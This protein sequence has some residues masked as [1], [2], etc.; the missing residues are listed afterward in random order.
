MK[1][2]QARFRRVCGWAG[3]VLALLPLVRSGAESESGG[4]PPLTAGA[5]IDY[6]PFCLVDAAGRPDGFSVELLRAAAGAMGRAV[7]FETGYWADV[8]DWLAEGRVAV[9]P[10]VGRTPEREAL[11]D[12]T[13]P[14]LTMHG[15][16]V[17]RDDRQDV[18]TL[19]DL[20]GLRVAV[21][22]GDNAEEYLRREAR[23]FDIQATP[24]FD[25]ALRGV[26]AGDYDAVVIQQLVALR[27]IDHLGLANLR[28]A[29][30]PLADFRQAFCFAV[31]KG[32]A[33]TLALLNEGLA[34]VIADGTFRRLHAK[35]F[36][37][38]ELPV[39]RPLVIGGDHAYPPFEFL[40]D[41]GRPAGLNSDLTRAIARERG[42]DV[43]IRLGPWSE[44]VHALAAGEI[45]ALQG[46]LYTPERDRRFDFAPAHVAVEYVLAAPGGTGGAPESLAQL[47]GRRVA[48]QR[49]DVAQDFL[50]QQAF[51]G[52]L[53]LLENQNDVLRA[54]ASGAVDYGLI[55]RRVALQALEDEPLNVRLGREPLLS[56]D[57]GYAVRAGDTA[58]LATLGEGLE[59]LRDSGDLQQ[60]RQQWLGVYETG[61][62]RLRAV[63]KRALIVIVP[64]V[65]L[66]LLS[67]AWSASLR[68]QVARRTAAL[69]ASEAYTRTILD[70]LPMG[71][72]V[73][74]VKPHVS[75]SYM[76]D[77][78]PVL[79]GTARD[80]LSDPEAFWTAVY[81]DPVFRDK[82][83]RRVEADCASGDPARMRWEDIPLAREGHETRY[84]SAANVPIPGRSEMIS[85]VWDVTDRVRGE[86]RIRHLNWVL[87][88][89]RDINQVIVRESD[90]QALIDEAARLLVAHR[91]YLSAVIV[92]TEGD[93]DRKPTT[94]SGAGLAS[95]SGAVQAQMAAGLLPDCCEHAVG[96]DGVVV[97]ENR[98]AICRGCP[99]AP[100]DPD[101]VVLAV[102]M[103]HDG[104]T[105]GFL[106][107]AQDPGEIVD[108]EERVLFEEIAG[109]LAYALH[110]IRT[111]SARDAAERERASL[112]EQLA[113]AQKLEAVG[114]LAGGVAHDFNNLLMGILGYADLCRASLDGT[115][116]AREWI[117]DIT[118]SAK[119][120]ADLTR[121][122]LAF[123]RRQTIEPK[124]IDL[125]AA[126]ESM[127]KL[128]RHLLGED[129]E[130]A[131]L[132]GPSVWPIIFDP[133]QLDQ[134]LANLC[135]NARDAIDGVGKLTVET[136]N[137]VIDQNYGAEHVEALPGEFAL[138]AVSDNGRGM[139]REVMAHIFEPFFTTKQHQGG[140]GLGLATIYGIV[141][142]NRGFVNVY[143]EPGKG[144]T[145]RIYL[146][147]AAGEAVPEASVSVAQGDDPGGA[148]TVMLVEDEAGIRKVVA[149]QLERLG[150]R[151]LVAADPETALRM[152]RAHAGV[153]HLLV[154]DVV[155]PGMSGRELADRLT[156]SRPGLKCLYMSGYTE[157]VIVHHGVLDPGVA[158][159]Q[160][161]VSMHALSRRIRAILDGPDGGRNA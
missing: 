32:D 71:I 150:Y 144:T 2:R 138:L 64:V 78:F 83:R 93:G 156:Q 90:P 29:G 47:A 111:A 99:L 108:A 38:L 77:R 72:A 134:I 33:Q 80:V 96:R 15:A 136:A 16:I 11:Y 25:D 4:P 58:L 73:N 18:R 53:V 69:R 128:L 3:I 94:W 14:Y 126:I 87:R 35:W 158:F 142:Q 161:P 154:T 20:R 24:S 13:F 84:V 97:V 143:S 103:R 140:T 54:V 100:P 113:Q 85:M 57:Y 106:L 6:P 123:A 1:A 27:L 19:K 118:C 137:R 55:A 23:D 86:H 39:D 34:L 60:I 92:L 116:P 117:D 31:R 155:M 115:H 79:Y 21:M 129:I 110:G 107:A 40:D 148:E 149:S 125:N 66:L 130:L 81:A 98:D 26:S 135:V 62:L 68:R 145:F 46:M 37:A 43:E 121:Q 147:R 151:L 48:L 104:V 139:T 50:A 119:R 61:S 95:E 91:S 56:L 22:R 63:L 30:P 76:N 82:L 109:D 10:L 36:A 114:R 42:L 105:Y 102:R 7:V 28:V 153:I 133:S 67:L 160:K 75:F 9:L 124:V 65:A 88:A 8:K 157:N 146:P 122:L 44:Q 70:N 41:A 59:M 5:E 89:I 52:I 141:K 49:G 51:E 127:L 159:L 131:W 152:A 132:P 101:A 112:S 12:F 120:S 17:V 74:T 45:D